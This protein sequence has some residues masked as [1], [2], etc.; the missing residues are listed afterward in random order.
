MNLYPHY[1][2]QYDQLL[3]LQTAG[4]S[5]AELDRAEDIA[6]TQVVE[7]LSSR[8]VGCSSVQADKSFGASL[9][10]HDI[11]GGKASL[12]YK[13]HLSRIVSILSA[14]ILLKWH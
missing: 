14:A 2:T 11:L 6:A 8:S 4:I 13:I 3:M 7:L 9:D 10:L 1:F 5:R 12:V